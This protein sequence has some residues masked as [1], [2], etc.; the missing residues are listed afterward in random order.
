MEIKAKQTARRLPDWLKRR[1]PAKGEAAAV[2]ALLDQLGLSTVCCGARCPNQSECFARGTA[3]FLILG[4]VCTRN[5]RF[6]AIPTSDPLPPREDEP[7]TVAQAAAEMK[8]NYV[9]VTS[10]TRDDLPDGGA[11]HFAQTIRAIRKRL[12]AAKVEVLTP[13]FCGD[14]SAIAAVLDARPDVF[15]HNI[16]T[17]ARLYPAIRPQAGYQQSLDVLAFAKRYALANDLPTLTKSGLMV[18]VGETDDEILATMRDLRGHECDILTIGQYLA[19]SGGHVTVERFVEPAT[20]DAWQAAA[21]AMGFRAAACGPFV[22]SS[23]HADDAFADAAEQP[24][25]A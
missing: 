10:V 1:V 14:E 4:E 23:Y 24:A 17:I 15:N 7:D 8:L 12:P 9:V 3:T 11:A 19:P 21:L 6:C 18:G 16:E 5:C 25:P 22:R 20:F 13:D 2:N